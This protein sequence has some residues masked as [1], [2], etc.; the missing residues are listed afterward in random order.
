[1]KLVYLFLICLLFSTSTVI[2]ENIAPSPKKINLKPYCPT[3]GNQQGTRTCVAFVFSHAM[4]IL[5]AIKHQHKRTTVIDSARF[6]P[7]FLYSQIKLEQQ[8]GAKYSTAIDFL[9]KQGNC[10][11]RDFNLEAHH[12]AISDSTIIKKALSNKI[13]SGG[14]VFDDMQT[15]KQKIDL[16]KDLLNDSIPIII[17]F[18]AYKSFVQLPKGSTSWVQKKDRADTYQDHH[19]LLVIGYD[20][21]HFEVMN[22]WGDDWA[23]DG[24]VKIAHSEL[25]QNS[26]RGYAISFEP[27]T[28][29]SLQPLTAEN[30]AENSSLGG[31]LPP[32]I[33][34]KP[35][36]ILIDKD[37]PEKGDALLNKAIS[38]KD[39]NILAVGSYL[40]N[41]DTRQLLF[42]KIK[43]NG[44][45][46]FTHKGQMNELYH[47]F[48]VSAVELVDHTLLVGGYATPLEDKTDL[49]QSNIWLNFHQADGKKI[50]RK[51][52]KRSILG[53]E[54]VAMK[55]I[56]DQLIFVGIENKNL[57]L[58]LTDLEGRVLMEKANYRKPSTDLAF[59]SAEILIQ[60]QFIYI[61]GSIRILH[62]KTK[63]FR[64]KS[65]IKKI[66]YLF[67]LDKQGA[68]LKEV[69]FL[70]IALEK[71]G[72]IAQDQEGQLIVT[73]TLS[74]D[75]K[76]KYFF[77]R[78]PPSLDKSLLILEKFGEQGDDNEGIDLVALEG[79]EILLLGNSKYN[80]SRTFDIFL[81][82]INRYGESKWKVP[83]LHGSKYDERSI[84]FIQKEDQSLWIAGLKNSGKGFKSDFN[85]WFLCVGKQRKSK[86]TIE[87][88]NKID[89]KS[90]QSKTSFLV[91]RIEHVSLK[92]KLKNK[93]L[94]Q[95]IK[96]KIQSICTDCPSNLDLSQQQKTINIL[97]G[98][99]QT[100][101]LLIETNRKTKYGDNTLTINFFNDANQIIF[102]E[103]LVLQ[104][105]NTEQ[106][107][108][109]LVNSSFNNGNNMIVEGE[110]VTLI[111]TFKNKSKRDYKQVKL[112][113]EEQ[114]DMI[115]LG[116]NHFEEQIWKSGAEKTFK[117][118]F[119]PD[120]TI[121]VN[122][123]SM[124]AFILF[125][126]KSTQITPFLIDPKIF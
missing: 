39:G 112:R 101:D 79:G 37:L 23:N 85:F 88:L 94:N 71:T 43:I 80:G 32:S 33:F 41:Q 13:K 114:E 93:H 100:I 120:K 6:S 59:Q 98:K 58:V 34:Q 1:M 76:G 50:K 11:Q 106:Q 102:Q 21:T 51:I 20:D 108:F 25:A 96:I 78:I 15:N 111:M 55:R 82:K 121:Q 125:G 83:W 7:Y 18:R 91:N 27:I 84:Q 8:K 9:K 40:N 60:N 103:N 17:N 64:S 49:L 22:S 69:K 97:A 26:V 123:F 115:L 48:G 116:V 75:E 90:Q 29:V 35:D 2:A 44:A 68:L 30:L 19:G 24:F 53:L 57:W 110:T 52:I 81:N 92:Y 14:M 107:P 38:T 28:S 66:P 95:A 77:L 72:K 113:L 63:S 62:K 122:R 16:L 67:K 70:D 31:Y 65:G 73:G 47:E 36:K 109:E 86:Q 74:H 104:I 42:S 119:I 124:N 5:Q 56:G 61:Y 99:T 89:I 4:T 118:K 54:L 126:K 117:L 105:I 10:R 45:K 46:L 12:K 3:P 87:E